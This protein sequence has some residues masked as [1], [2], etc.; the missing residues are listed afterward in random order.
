MEIDPDHIPSEIQALESFLI[1]KNI[2]KEDGKMTKS[3]VS[4]AGLGSPITILMNSCLS[5]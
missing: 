5:N 1:W 4:S 3:P 2:R